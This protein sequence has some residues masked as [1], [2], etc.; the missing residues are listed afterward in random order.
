MATTGSTAAWEAARSLGGAGNDVVKAEP[1]D[2]AAIHG[3][4]YIDGGAGNAKLYGNYQPDSIHGGPGKDAI[5]GGV[6]FH[7]P[8]TARDDV[9]MLFGD[10]GSDRIDATGDFFQTD[11]VDC[12]NEIDRAIVYAGID[13]TTNCERIVNSK[14]G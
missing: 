11:V 2:D 3:V 1:F 5:S 6:S 9:D 13:T 14:R 8:N 12:G 10:D 7:S 4:N